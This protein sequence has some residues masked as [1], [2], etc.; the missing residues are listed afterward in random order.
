MAADP[1]APSGWAGVE[2]GWAVA[3]TLLAGILVLGG[4]GYLAD[5][6][7]GWNHVLLPIGVVVGGGLGIYAVWLQYGRD[8]D[9]DDRT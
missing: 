4:L 3:S 6:L 5:R 8:S 1:K 7:A 9:S 2:A